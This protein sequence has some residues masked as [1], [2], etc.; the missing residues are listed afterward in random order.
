MNSMVA[1]HNC[2]FI[3]HQYN[4]T[5]QLVKVGIKLGLGDI[6]FTSADGSVS[7]DHSVENILF[8][9]VFRVNQSCFTLKSKSYF[10][11][12]YYFESFEIK[13]YSYRE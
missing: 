8:L 7:I 3:E 9:Q 4:D 2:N 1:N 11:V 6:L 12:Q 5:A 10:R 13:I